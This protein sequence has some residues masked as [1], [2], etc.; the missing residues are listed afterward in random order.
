MD[1]E[2]T[3]WDFVA[4]LEAV[5]TGS[6]ME[7]LLGDRQIAEPPIFQLGSTDILDFGNY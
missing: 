7:V 6:S 4:K 3:D 1:G 5:V 2:R